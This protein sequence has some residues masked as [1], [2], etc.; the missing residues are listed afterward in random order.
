M[1]NRNSVRVLAASFAAAGLLA[2]LGAGTAQAG[3]Q[4]WR[5]QKLVES[6]RKA[7]AEAAVPGLKAITQAPQAGEIESLTLDAG[8]AASDNWCGGTMVIGGQTV[9]IPRNLLID[10]PAN[11]LSLKQAFEQASAGCV[12]VNQSGLARTDSCR[13][14][15]KGAFATLSSNRD[16]CGRTIVGDLFIANGPEFVTSRVTFINFTEGYFRLG[17]TLGTDAGGTIVRANDPTGR[18]TIQQ[19]TGCVA[20]TPNCS[21]DIRFNSDPDNYTVSFKDGYPACLPSRS[22]TSSHPVAAGPTGAG[23]PLCPDTNRTAAVAPNFFVNDSRRF[24][25]VQVGDTVAA[26]GGF[27]TVGGV[28]YLSAHTINVILGLSTRETADQPDYVSFERVVW[29]LAP[30]PET[31]S[32][33]VFTGFSTLP[34][35]QLDIFALRVDPRTNTPTQDPLTSTVGNPKTTNRLRAGPGG[36]FQISLDVHLLAGAPVPPSIS[37]CIHLANAGFATC[38]GGGTLAEEFSVLSPPSR[39]IQ[40]VSRRRVPV[41]PGIFAVDIRG[42]RTQSGEFTI[43]LGAGLGGVVLGEPGEADLGTGFDP[44]MLEALPWTLDR[45]TSPTGC[46]SAGCEAAAQPLIPYPVSGKDIRNLSIANGA[47]ASVVDRV[48]TFFTSVGGRLI[49]HLLTVPPGAACAAPVEALHVDVAEFRSFTRTW[50]VTGTDSLTTPGTVITVF[51]GPAVGGTV[52]GTAPVSPS[53]GWIMVRAGSPVSR[54]NR[55]S[56]QSSAG[57]KLEN[58]AVTIRL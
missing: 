33:A 25:P 45:R 48:I 39:E 49:P 21:P 53:G 50:T 6:A 41:S 15:T 20:G 5:Y 2:V 18:F 42:R 12:S 54:A 9:V 52:I 11:R 13:I 37:P 1:K 38:S 32:R 57:A 29:A 10:F 26:S 30:F 22:V 51:S 4:A 55:I 19:G 24:A 8:C 56:V 35:S 27:V 28:T 47:P 17:G 40:A 16:D 46:T 44:L 34:N 23:D 31:H 58:I 14:A 7:E 43:P 3:V 36:K